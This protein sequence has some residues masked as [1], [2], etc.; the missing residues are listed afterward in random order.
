MSQACGVLRRVVCSSPSLYG[1]ITGRMSSSLADDDQN[2]RPVAEGATRAGHPH[3]LQSEERLGQLAEIF[4]VRNLLAA[5]AL[6]RDHR[7]NVVVCGGRRSEPPPCRRR[8]D[9]GRAPS[10][11]KI[12]RKAGPAFAQDNRAKS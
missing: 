6:L 5:V 3:C 2:P 7:S 12:S 4:A 10:L 9:K 1:E 11:P 8:R